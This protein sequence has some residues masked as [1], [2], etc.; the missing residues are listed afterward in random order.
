MM[1]QQILPN[2]SQARNGLGGL[3]P[4]GTARRLANRPGVLR[5]T[6]GQVWL[7]RAGHLE[8]EVLSA[9]QWRCLGAGEAAVIESWQP[10]VDAR[11][12]WLPS[13]P[14]WLPLRV[15]RALRLRAWRRL[16]GLAGSMAWVS[17]AARQRFDTLARNAAGGGAR[18]R[19]GA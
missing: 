18:A 17:E 11:F 7:T 2:R 14:G 1:Y 13:P 6:H 8:D 19:G 3:L 9:G 16:A 4:G 10:S 5:V 12:Q 15:A